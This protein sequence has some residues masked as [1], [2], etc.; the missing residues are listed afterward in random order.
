MFESKD[1]TAPDF[2]PALVICAWDIDEAGWDPVE[3]LSGES[4]NP[5][6]ARTLPVAA[7]EPEALAAVLSAH[8]DDRS[9]RGLLLVGRTRCSDAFRVQ[10]RA[11][12]RSLDGQRHDIVGPR[13][14]RATAPVADIVRALNEAG[15]AADASS[16]SE[17]DAGSYLLYR[18]LS[19][20]PDGQDTPAIGLL[21][22]PEHETDVA[23]QRAVKAAAQ[24]M[25]HHLSPLPRSR[26]N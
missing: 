14:A 2:R 21:R 8:L 16:D 15:L 22:A 3:D 23:V 6:G 13:T 12:N 19:D 17:D 5:I 18:I 1:E 7:G 10:I 11:E 25:A 20:L 26:A 9:C 4:W 24:A